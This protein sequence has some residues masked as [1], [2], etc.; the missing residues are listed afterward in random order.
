MYILHTNHAPPFLSLPPSPLP[1]PSPPSPLPPPFPSLPLRNLPS[2]PLP[3]FPSLP[4][5]QWRQGQLLQH[6]AV[7]CCRPRNCG[8]RQSSATGQ[9]SNLQQ[10]RTSFIATFSSTSLVPILTVGNESSLSSCCHGDVITIVFS[11]QTSWTVSC[12]RRSATRAWHSTQ[13]PCV[14]RCIEVSLGASRA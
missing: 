11:L 8:T 6:D 7:R 13:R 2:L 14:C 12:S 3:P 4:S 1:H 9:R 5:L 10:S